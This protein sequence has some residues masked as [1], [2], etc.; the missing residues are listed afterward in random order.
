MPVI[1]GLK[2][3]WKLAYQSRLSCH[4]NQVSSHYLVNLTSF[5]F[6]SVVICN[7]LLRTGVHC[8]AV[9][10]LFYFLSAFGGTYFFQTHPV[11]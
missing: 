10:V 8:L 1:F 7:S 5:S 2:K 11:R 6:V 3:S 4:L 9:H